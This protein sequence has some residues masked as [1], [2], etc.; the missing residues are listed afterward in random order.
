MKGLK[1]AALVL[2]VLLVGL[3]AFGFYFYTSGGAGLTR[4][5]INYLIPNL[6]DKRY[7]WDDFRYR[8]EKEKVS[9]FYSS[10]NTES[11]SMGLPLPTGGA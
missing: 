2:T 8:G 7:T 4:I 6:P 11:F 5:V 1:I 9:G 3:A 10:S